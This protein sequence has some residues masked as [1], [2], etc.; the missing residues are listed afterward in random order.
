M[1]LIVRCGLYV[2]NTALSMQKKQLC[3]PCILTF[4]DFFLLLLMK[5]R[6]ACCFFTLFLACLTDK[7][8]KLWKISERDRRPEGYNLKEEDGRYKHPNTITSLRVSLNCLVW[9]T[10]WHL[11][12]H[13]KT[14]RLWLLVSYDKTVIF[15]FFFS[16]LSKCLVLV[17]LSIGFGQ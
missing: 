9:S 17:L 12:Q 16:L 5:Q 3:F 10:P 2:E 4:V 7:T 8:I 15:R 13:I 11:D 1:R 14:H 6:L